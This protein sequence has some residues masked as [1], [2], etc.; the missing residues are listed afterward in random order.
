MWRHKYDNL[1]GAP[2]SQIMTGRVFPRVFMWRHKY[3]NY[4]VGAPMSQIMTGRAF[5]RVFMWRHNY[6]NLVGAPMFWISI[7][8]WNKYLKLIVSGLFSLVLRPFLGEW[9]IPGSTHSPKE[10]GLAWFYHKVEH[11]NPRCTSQSS[12]SGRETMPRTSCCPASDKT[13]VRLLL[14]FNVPSTA[15]IH[16]RTIHTFNLF[17][18]QLKTQI[19]ETQ[20]YIIQCYKVQTKPPIYQCTV[21]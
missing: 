11:G 15:Y 7:T 4:L 3:H 20:V 21:A 6:D 19:T 12:S 18:H 9:T 14:D 1:V 16:L 10:N 2:V 13:Q 5:P 8:M 17:L